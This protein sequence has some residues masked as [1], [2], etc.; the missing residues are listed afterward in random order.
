M[1]HT[2]DIDAFIENLPPMT[3]AERTE[4]ML[5]YVNARI[6]RMSAEHLRLYR[7]ECLQVYA[8]TPGLA[9]VLDMIDGM[10]ALREMGLG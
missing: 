8:P 9:V 2:D 5:T 1:D 10:L 4:V 6:R 3:D 7:A